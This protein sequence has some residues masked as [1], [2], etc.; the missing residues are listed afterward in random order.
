MTARG[1]SYTISWDTTLIEATRLGCDRRYVVTNIKTGTTEWLY[2][3][4]YC[5]R[6]QA[7]NLIK[8]HKT[9]LASDRTSCRSP[10]ANHVDTSD[11][12]FSEGVVLCVSRPCRFLV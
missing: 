1:A 10:L 8:L 6:G 9:Q 3:S 11:N 5:A 7:E 12:L 4:L 2:D